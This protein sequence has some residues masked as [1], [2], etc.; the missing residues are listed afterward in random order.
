M[1]QY[2]YFVIYACSAC[3]IKRCV[4]NAVRDPP[5]ETSYFSAPACY[6]LPIVGGSVAHHAGFSCDNTPTSSAVSS[7]TVGRIDTSVDAAIYS[8]GMYT[9]GL[10]VKP[11]SCQGQES[12][13]TTYSVN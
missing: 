2:A 4:G 10:L 9:W 3:R 6:T 5:W 11:M 1:T 8:D 7:G 13:T 12:V